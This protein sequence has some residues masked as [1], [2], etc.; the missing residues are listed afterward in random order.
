M[1]FEFEWMLW[2]VTL[3]YFLLRSYLGISEQFRWF[4]LSPRSVIPNK[5]RVRT[6]RT[7]I[8]LSHN[9]SFDVSPA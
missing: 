1:K 7:N 3:L 9:I 6:G 5:V 4:S 8:F 2:L